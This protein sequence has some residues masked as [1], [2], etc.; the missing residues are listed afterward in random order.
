M[1]SEN[2]W[3]PFYPGDYLRDTM[4][5]RLEHHGAYLLLL[6]C[7][8]DAK[9]VMPDDDETFAGI[10]RV[11]LD[12]WKSKFRPKLAPFFKIS[13]GQWTQSRVQREYNRSQHV[14]KVRSEV[15]KLGGRPKQHESKTQSK[16]KA[17][18]IANDKQNETSHSHSHSHSQNTQSQSEIIYA[19]YPRKVSRKKALLKIEAALKTHGF[20]LVNDA[21]ARFSEAWKGATDLRFCPHPM[22]WFG[23]E[24]F[25]D[26]P[27]TWKNGH[28]KT[29][30]IPNHE[31]GF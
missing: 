27:E 25:L 11:P 10:V 24:R 16:E 7:F 19:Q 26:A 4:H 29:A 3:F 6:L 5:L 18:G 22:T 21:V 12:D 14:R 8:W 31:K 15:G 9:G 30:L 2:I 28:S 20:E 1:S 23:Q 17:I 13:N